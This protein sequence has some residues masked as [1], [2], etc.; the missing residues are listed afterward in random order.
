MD[1][2]KALEKFGGSARWAQLRTAG[3][4]RKTLAAAVLSK[5]ILRPVRGTYAL[6]GT[7]WPLIIATGQSA[8]LTCVSAAELHG[9]WVWRAPRVPHL[10]VC[11]AKPPGEYV[12]HRESSSSF[13]LQ[14]SLACVAQALFCLPKLEALCIA[15]SAVVLKR[16]TLNELL[17]ALPRKGRVHARRVLQQI[18]IRSQSIVETIARETLRNAGFT[19]QCQVYFDG[20]GHVD[21]LVNGL[22]VI[23]LDGRKYHSSDDAFV[24]D[25]RR[26]NALTALGIPVLRFPAAQILANPHSI[27]SV[28]IGTLR[29]NTPQQIVVPE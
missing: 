17:S 8:V 23:E 22:L 3:V 10:S 21:L 5:Q 14:S 2:C 28:V 25:R 15:E 26:W 18:D 11:W 16:H 19:V 1:P 4:A 29:Q 7:P 6:P 27:L 13:G 20:V 12:L 9:L 24:E